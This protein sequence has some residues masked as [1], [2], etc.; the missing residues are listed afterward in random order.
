MTK[1]T[2]DHRER[3]LGQLADALEQ[4]IDQ[5]WLYFL[6]LGKPGDDHTFNLVSNVPPDKADE[7][8]KAFI[9]VCKRQTMHPL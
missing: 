4:Y 3:R 8:M 2:F 7:F 1:E 9:E 6:F 5:D